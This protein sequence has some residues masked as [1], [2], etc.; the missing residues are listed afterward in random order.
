MTQTSIG[1]LEEFGVDVRPDS[2]LTTDEI[3]ARNVRVVDLHFH[4]ENPDDVEK[5]VGLYTDDIT[6]E[7]PA[8]G[9]IMKDPQ[10]VLAAYRNIFQ[11][12]AYRKTVAL[13]RFA[14]ERFVFDDQVAYLKVVGEPTLMHNFPFPHG[15]EV[16]VR[17]VHCF[18]M[19]DGRIAREIAYEIWRKVGSAVDSDDIPEGAPVEVFPDLPA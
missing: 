8:R 18:E 13:R 15:T 2:E 1:I 14:T 10:E 11:V 6:W 16:S 5:A 4:T 17:L 3:V 12:L 7:A 9:V 19:R